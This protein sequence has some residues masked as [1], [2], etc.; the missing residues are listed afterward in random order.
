[1]RHGACANQGTTSG[2]QS[3]PTNFNQGNLALAAATAREAL[4]QRASERLG[5]PADQLV[6]RNGDISLKADASTSVTYGALVGGRPFAMT[7]NRDAK[8]KPPSEWTILGTAVPRV[9]IPDMATGRF[10]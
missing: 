9:D 2:A 1:M 10:E 7:L 6:A 3:H 8:R 4:L 5:V